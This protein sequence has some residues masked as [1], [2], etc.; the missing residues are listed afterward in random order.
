MPRTVPAALGQKGCN[1]VILPRN[2]I[3]LRP[4]PQPYSKRNVICII[5]FIT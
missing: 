5:T 3:T 4:R 1:S 2:V